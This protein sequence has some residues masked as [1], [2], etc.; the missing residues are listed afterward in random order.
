V[1]ALRGWSVGRVSE[2]GGSECR[3]KVKER[4]ARNCRSG[5]HAGHVR[6]VEKGSGAVRRAGG[7]DARL[8]GAR[9][10]KCEALEYVPEIE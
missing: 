2:R 6:R 5:S 4:R 9:A 3:W 10:R 1:V 8:H 7:G